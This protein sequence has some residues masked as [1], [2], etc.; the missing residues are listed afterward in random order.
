SGDNCRR[1]CLQLVPQPHASSNWVAWE[2]VTADVRSPPMTDA[3]FVV[4]ANRL[5]VDRVVNEDGSEAWRTSPG[6]LVAA[7]EPVMR[8]VDGAWVGWPGQADLELEPFTEN[9]ITLIPIS[10]SAQEVE[11]F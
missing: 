6:G 10:L 11:E 9:G 7:L 5:P 1:W 3:E 8:T 4:V 2:D